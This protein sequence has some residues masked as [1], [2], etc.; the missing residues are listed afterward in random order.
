MLV[1]V[2]ANSPESARVAEQ[3]GAD[4]VELC[5]ELALGG[6][7][8]SAGLLEWVRRHVR[9]PVHVLIRPRS[10]D[11]LYSEAELDC[12]LADIRTCVAMGFAGI[13]SGCLQADR[14]IDQEATRR[15]REAAGTCHFT[16][17]RAFDRCP[18]PV[19]ALQALEQLGVNTILS[20]GQAADAVAGL[21]LLRRLHGLAQDC[22]VMPGGGINP[23]NA[24]VFEAAGFTAIHLSGVPKPTGPEPDAGLPMN[25]LSLLREGRPL[26]TDPAIV[27]AVIGSLNKGPK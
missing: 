2:C 11:F 17:H 4:R 3:A 6:I 12:M 18:D 1:E 13:V 21:P 15:L 23:G 7:T 16:F 22:Q 5:S 24:Q 19:A 27:A 10:G 20:S 8:P 9:I 14:H 25:S 26:H